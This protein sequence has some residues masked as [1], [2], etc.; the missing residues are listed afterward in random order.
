MKLHEQLGV[1]SENEWNKRER[2]RSEEE[3]EEEA[4]R[5]WKNESIE[6][7]VGSSHLPKSAKE[8]IHS[9]LA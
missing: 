2:R 1:G 7:Y 6:T 9:L 4:R 5:K 8:P 3:M